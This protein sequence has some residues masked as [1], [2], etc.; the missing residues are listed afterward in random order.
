MNENDRILKERLLAHMAFSKS[1]LYDVLIDFLDSCIED[2]Q[3]DAISNKFTGE[4][5]AWQCGRASALKDFK[6]QVTGIREEVRKLY[7]DSQEG[8][9][10]IS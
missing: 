6:I 4:E 9:E 1:D 5:R 10:K 7:L 8:T 3:N 2:E